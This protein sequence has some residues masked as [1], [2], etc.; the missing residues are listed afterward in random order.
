[1]GFCEILAAESGKPERR[2]VGR[3]AFSRALL[4]LPTGRT[5]LLY[6]GRE[7]LRLRRLDRARDDL[8]RALALEECPHLAHYFLALLEA[9]CGNE[10]RAVDHLVESAKFDWGVAKRVRREPDLEALRADARLR[11]WLKTVEKR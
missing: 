8:E 2:D 11:A 5:C 3:R 7:L 10:G 9:A 1:V 6:R 4:E